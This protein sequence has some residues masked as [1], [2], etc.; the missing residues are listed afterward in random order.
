MA[1]NNLT[2]FRLNALQAQEGFRRWTVAKDNIIASFTLSL[3][4]VLEKHK[5]VRPFLICKIC[6]NI[7]N[8]AVT[9]N[10]CTALFC[11]QCIEAHATVD[12]K[13]SACPDEKPFK[14]KAI[15]VYAAEFLRELEFLCPVP[16]C[17]RV[18]S[19]NEIQ[20][21][22]KQCPAQKFS[23]GYGCD[24]ASSFANLKELETH[25]KEECLTVIHDCQEC[26]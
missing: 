8:S 6:T 22:F 12:K 4:S 21:H 17:D 13:C 1:Y 3:N 11:E 2:K 20:A 18:F 25:F 15:P 19:I 14:T 24:S 26:G 23:C 9:C 7:V 10:R 16:T 5:P